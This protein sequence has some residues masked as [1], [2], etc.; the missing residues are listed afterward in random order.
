MVG[1]GKRGQAKGFELGP[2]RRNVGLNIG[3]GETIELKKLNESQSGKMRHSRNIS[4]DEL[5]KL[6]K[7]GK[8]GGVGTGCFGAKCSVNPK[9]GPT[10]E[11]LENRQ[12]VYKYIRKLIFKFLGLNTSAL[13]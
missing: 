12:G 9:S 4:V 1:Q 10:H 11:G 8:M 5:K 3:G 7:E 13:L 6:E 2:E